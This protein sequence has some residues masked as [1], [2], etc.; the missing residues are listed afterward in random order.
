MH[1]SETGILQTSLT[2]AM[3]GGVAGSSAMILQV[4]SLM[5][6]RTTMNYQYRYGTTFLGTIRKLYNQGGIPRFYR[7][8]TPALLQGPLSRFGDTAANV[9]VL[10]YLDKN[11]N[12]SNLNIGVK[13]AIASGIASLWRINLMPLDTIKTMLQVNGKKTFKILKYKY[14]MGGPSI[15]YHGSLGAFGATYMGYFPWFYT[16]NLLNEKLPEYRENEL[17]RLSRSAAIGFTAS[18][19]SDCIS[20]SMRVIKTSKQSYHKP[21]SYF[22][23]T[24]KIIEK[25]GIIGLMGRG[26]KTRL[27]SNALQGM[28]F[29]VLWRLFIDKME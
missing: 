7:G 2:K 28:M 22:D 9:G 1:N 16:F 18:V 25:D 6:L 29:A 21:I 17:K 12:T 15:F 11:E 5:W 3:K 23:I 8:L 26:L 4:C 24:N 14:K 27:L 13:T 10:A 19:T 20:N